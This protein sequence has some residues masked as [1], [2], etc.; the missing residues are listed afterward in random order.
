V[1]WAKPYMANKRKLLPV[2]VNC[3]EGQYDIDEAFKVAT[4]CS[5]MPCNKI[6]AETKHAR[7]YH[8]FGVPAASS[9][10]S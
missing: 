2:L 5:V 6:Q 4:L 7:S 10:A 1:E 8:R 9:C 3:I